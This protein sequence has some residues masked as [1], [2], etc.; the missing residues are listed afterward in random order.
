MMDKYIFTID[1]YQYLKLMVNKTIKLKH[2][3]MKV[4]F[5][6]IMM[7][8]N[9]KTKTYSYSIKTNKKNKFN[10]KAAQRKKL[11]IK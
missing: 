7:I 2:N 9:K 3:K 8:K 10:T 1:L 4:E 6:L 5:S 11:L